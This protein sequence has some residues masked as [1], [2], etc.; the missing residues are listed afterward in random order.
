MDVV[1]SVT[2]RQIS[3]LDLD[4][5]R[6]ASQTFLMYQGERLVTPNGMPVCD[7]AAKVMEVVLDDLQTARQ[8]NLSGAQLELTANLTCYEI[9]I[10]RTQG[11]GRSSTVDLSMWTEQEPLLN[12]VLEGTAQLTETRPVLEFFGRPGHRLLVPSNEPAAWV[13][14]VWNELD[15]VQRAVVEALIRRHSVA[16]TVAS[17]FA[18]RGLATKQYARAVWRIR[19]RT[20][21]GFRRRDA[22]LQFGHF[23]DIWRDARRAERYL[24]A[25]I[26][27]LEALF[28]KGESTNLEFKTTLR[29]N[30]RTEN[31]DRVILNASLKTIAAFLNTEGGILAIGVTDEGSPV[32][33]LLELDGLETEDK[34]LRHLFSKMRDT[35]GGAASSAV[36]AHFETVHGCPVCVVRCSK[37]AVPVFAVLNKNSEEF[38]VRN[39][40][41]TESL[42]VREAVRHIRRRFPDYRG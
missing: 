1:G 5:E 39:G 6:Q 13:K 31:I 28:G 42:S 15:E 17:A 29:K 20:D 16:F 24:V 38:F 19:E 30:V 22:A 7:E 40:P 35:F 11:K 14:R 2:R 32:E 4:L 25:N 10:R 9:H 33:N 8:V 26:D 18:L 41:S 23:E 27:P 12:G 21:A 36:T 3:P 34:Y 37:N